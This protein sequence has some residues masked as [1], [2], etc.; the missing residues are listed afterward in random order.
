MGPITPAPAGR[1]GGEVR[2]LVKPSSS[3]AP[4]LA[5][6]ALMGACMVQ[7][8]AARVQAAEGIVRGDDAAESARV[9]LLL[10]RLA[11]RV[12]A[13]VPGA[14]LPEDL[15]VWVQESPRLY[16]LPGMG[17]ADAEG[18]YSAHHSR[19]LLSRAA[20]DLERTLAHELAH[21]ALGE[22]WALLPGTVEEGLCDLVS[23][24]LCPEGAT[25]LR[26]GRLCS[27]ALACGGLALELRLQS[28]SDGR[29]WVARVTLAGEDQ[30]EDPQRA[31]FAVE[32]GLSSTAL[33]TGTKRGFYGLAYLLVSRAAE[34]VGLDGL[35]A[36]CEEATTEGLDRVP[37]A[38]LLEAAGLEDS[39]EAWRS[40]A[41]AAL[42]PEELRA[43]VV[44][45]P[46]FVVDALDGWLHDQSLEAGWPEG[47]TLQVALPG[48]AVADLSGDA[49][50]LEQLRARRAGAAQPASSR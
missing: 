17:V 1:C 38:Q 10:D 50:L 48:G 43:L 13:L 23:E 45:Y 6:A 11:P 47:V 22:E 28:G 4:L 5:V 41:A 35:H 25:R 3:K 19:I 2:F 15:E 12:Q 37:A 9:S 27:A 30:G 33:T 18:L 8:P 21:A 20:D 7:P 31:V 24:L 32:A 44:M 40:A 39:R 49:S 36:L 42:G 16:A 29:Q 34:R 14:D 26:A 46:H